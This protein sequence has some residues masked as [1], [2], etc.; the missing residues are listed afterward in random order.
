M[1][2]GG[3]FVVLTD[4]NGDEF[5]LELLS[6]LELNDEIYMAFAPTDVSDDD[7]EIGIVILQSVEEE[8]GEEV[9]VTVDDEA[10]LEKVYARFMEQ[11]EADNA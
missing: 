6:T 1:E 4:E 11:M 8:D 9:L 3:S 5:E 10:L 7:E 2:E